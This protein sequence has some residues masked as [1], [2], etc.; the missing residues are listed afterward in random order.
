M[1]MF[2]RGKLCGMCGERGEGGDGASNRE[3]RVSNGDQQR[4]GQSSAYCG[5]HDAGISCRPGP[6]SAEC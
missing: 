5:D 3:N 2:N 6:D 1:Y 4:C